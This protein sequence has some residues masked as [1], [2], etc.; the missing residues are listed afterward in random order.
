MV[1]AGQVIR[2]F[3]MAQAGTNFNHQVQS[4]KSDDHKLV[5]TGLY[6]YFRHPAY[7]AYFWWALGTQLVLG[8]T[9]SLVGYALVLWYFFKT[10]IT[11]TYKE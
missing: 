7:F 9:I 1:I 2:S 8:N 4:R 6:A 5:S 10:R 11:R 3:A